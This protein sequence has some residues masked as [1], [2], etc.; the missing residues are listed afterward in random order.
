MNERNLLCLLLPVLLIGGA[1]SA[2]ESTNVP[3]SSGA[4]SV[5]ALKIA[6]GQPGPPAAP[7]IPLLTAGSLAPDFVS[8]DLAG[9]TVRLAESK[10][11]VMV[12]DFWAT[13]CGPCQKSLPHTQEVAKHF[14]D[15]GVVVLASC[16]SDTR[17]KFDEWVKANQEKYPNIIFTCDP[18]EKGSATFADRAAKKLYGVSGIP[19]RFV[20]GRDGKIVASLVGYYT[21]DARLEASLAKAGVQVDPVLVAKGEEQIAKRSK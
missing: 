17:A 1:A 21:D 18:N 15:Q 6:P 20:I 10:G 4:P 14:K 11:K 13:W 3:G 2:Q 12:L 19:T 5:P 16:T 7:G 8:T 9:K